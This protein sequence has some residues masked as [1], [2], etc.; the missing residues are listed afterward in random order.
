MIRLMDLRDGGE[1]QLGAA[2]LFG[3]GDGLSLVR[4]V[5]DF[6]LRMI[7]TILGW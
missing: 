1:G 3:G 4:F 6:I 5:R 2:F 7:S